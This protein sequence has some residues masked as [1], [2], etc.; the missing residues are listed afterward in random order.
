[1]GNSTERRRSSNEKEKYCIIDC[2]V[3][4]CHNTFEWKCTGAGCNEEC[5][6]ADKKT[7]ET[8]E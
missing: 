5:N 3:L 4:L 8:D 2:S 7:V 6:I 1:V